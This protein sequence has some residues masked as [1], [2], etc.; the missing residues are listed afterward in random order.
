MTE[1]AKLQLMSIQRIFLIAIICCNSWASCQAQ[2]RVII[3]QGRSYVNINNSFHQ[4]EAGELLSD[5]VSI[6]L[7]DN[8]AL[9]LL[10]KEGRF[11]VLN[12]TG[13]YKLNNF[14]SKENSNSSEVIS[15]IW[16]NHFENNKVNQSAE[17][18]ELVR[19][20]AFELY[21]PSSSEAYGFDLFLKWTA[22]P[23]GNYRI[24][25]LD[26]YENLFTEINTAKAEYKLD[27]L[28]KKLAWK[29]QVFI[30]V[31]ELT[32]NLNTGLKAIAK[33]SP[34]DLD[35][36]NSILPLLPKGD[37]EV[38]VLTR[39]A[40]FEQKGWVADVH[41]LLFESAKKNE[42][43][44]AYYITFLERNRYFSLINEVRK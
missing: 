38:A 34:P 13:S 17:P 11:L 30:R 7:V 28:S 20:E 35:D 39:A 42:I 26:E 29:R 19:S 40:F 14:S 25:L 2:Y 32:N 15:Q 12:K 8:A 31:R 10:D 4:L 21:L 3:A 43:L 16:N 9:T 5:S 44:K 41:N 24:E 1:L 27:L 36:A 37:D 33:L 22:V 6:D 18:V 23:N